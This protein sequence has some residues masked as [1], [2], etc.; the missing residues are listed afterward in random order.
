MTKKDYI[1]IAK[2]INSAKSAL[3][4]ASVNMGETNRCIEI[5]V[6]NL[7]YLLRGNNHKFD[8][9]RFKE[10]CGIESQI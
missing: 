10:A 7:S 8:E 9:T 2:A 3:S 6:A 4:Y 5:V 1:L